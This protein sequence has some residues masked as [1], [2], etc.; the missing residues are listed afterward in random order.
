MS[1][2]GARR[3]DSLDNKLF[4]LAFDSVSRFVPTNLSLLYVLCDG[5]ARIF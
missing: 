2:E 3:E 4:I 5:L 1:L